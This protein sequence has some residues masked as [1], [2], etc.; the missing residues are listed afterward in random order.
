MSLILLTIFTA[1][2]TCKAYQF[3]SKTYIVQLTSPQ[4]QHLSLD[5]RPHDLEQRYSLFLSKIG[6][7][8][9]TSK[10]WKPIRIIHAYHHAVTGFAAQMSSEQANAIQNMRGVVSVSPERHFR[11]HTTHSA[12]FLGLSHNSG[13]WKDSNH[14]KGIIIGVLD[15]GTTP[16]HPSFHDFGVPTPPERWKGRCEVG[17]RQ[18]CNNKLIGM[19]NFVRSTSSPL[20]TL[21]HG[22]HTSS[23]A[24]GNFVDNANIF[25]NFNGT[26]TGMAPF[27]HL[28]MYK[29]CNREYCSESD[30][31]AGMDAAIGDGVDVLSISFGG[32]S[33]PF[34]RDSMAISA[35]KAIQKGIFV[36]CSGGNSGPFK[37]TLSNT[38]PWVLTVGASTTDRRIRTTVYLGN[39][40]L[41]DGESLYQPKSFHQKLMPLVYPGGNGDYKAATCSRGSLDNIDVNG[42][43]VLCD[44]GGTIWTVDKGRVVKDAGGAAM[45]LRNGIACPETTVPE[46]HVLPASNVGYKEGLEI[47]KYLNSTS[48]PVATIL[49]HGT[50]LGVKSAPEVACFSSRGPNLASPGILK[51]D[52]IGPGVDILAA[53]PLLMPMMTKLPTFKIMSG[54]SMACPHL[55]GVAALLKSRHPE[56]SPA[57]IKSAMMTTASQVSLYGKPIVDHETDLPADMFAIGAGHVNPSKANDPGL[58]FDIQPDD[59]IPYLCGLGYTTKQIS[60]IVKKP[61]SCIKSIKET[62]LNYPSFVV[63][64]KSDDTKTYSRSVTN[65]GMPNS[66]YTIGNVSVPQGVR[67]CIVVDTS[68]QRLR[69]IAMYQKLTYNIT[70]TR[71]IMDKVKSRYGQGYMT[72]VSGKYSVRTPFLFNFF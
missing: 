28:A 26:A 68:S 33:V 13:L 24:A 9:T 71:D 8:N 58:V 11:L 50:I 55:A 40:K 7:D 15:T 45:V 18:Y 64:L 29:V 70:F 53:W 69:F 35:F 47:I 32:A 44:M 43:V 21:G 42:K 60:M 72:W 66:I 4:G 34:Y 12:Q 1:F 54:T 52:I 67:V 63:T 20:D 62:E 57:A 16:H 25:G 14:G 27:A 65:V 49:Q 36:S 38:V 51:P 22:T 23:T 5:H 48:S 37:G 41:I 61:F 39:K 59:Y 3:K 30:S 19:R 31:I 2:P 6:N 17:V 10:L 56:W 46:A